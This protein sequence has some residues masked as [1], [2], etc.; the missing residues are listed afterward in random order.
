MNTHIIG[1]VPQPK[2]LHYIRY[3]QEKA[4]RLKANPE[5]ESSW[6]NRNPAEEQYGGG[7][8]AGGYIL[9]FSGLAELTDEAL[10][11]AIAAR[12]GLQTEESL[13]DIAHLS[14]SHELFHT[15][16]YPELIAVGT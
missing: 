2:C 11:L 13:R 16:L 9:S 1:D 3:A 4:R 7:I 14:G 15:L 8:C 10:V 5:L 12:V 6:R